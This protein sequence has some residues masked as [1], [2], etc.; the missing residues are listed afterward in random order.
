[1]MINGKSITR[2]EHHA[3][4]C[5]HRT[6]CRHIYLETGKLIAEICSVFV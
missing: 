3:S 2:E 6:Y 5:Y 4:M 1:M